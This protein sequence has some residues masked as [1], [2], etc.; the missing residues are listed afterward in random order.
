MIFGDE[1]WQSFGTMYQKD[2]E[3]AMEIGMEVLEI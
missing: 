3:A 1:L 2:P